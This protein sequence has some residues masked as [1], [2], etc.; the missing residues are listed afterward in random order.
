[1]RL[2]CFYPEGPIG[3][4][5]CAPWPEWEILHFEFLS[6]MIKKLI[7]SFSIPQFFPWH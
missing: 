3:C 6:F 5:L 1:M 4:V 7:I 2:V